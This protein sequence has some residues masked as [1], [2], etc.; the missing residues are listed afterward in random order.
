M[1]SNLMRVSGIAEINV[2]GGHLVP[3]ADLTARCGLGSPCSLLGKI[4]FPLQLVIGTIKR[5]E[6][7]I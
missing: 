5:E 3:D 1:T 2:A 4:I 6:K 7:N